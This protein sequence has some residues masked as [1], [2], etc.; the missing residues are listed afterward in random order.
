MKDWLTSKGIE[1]PDCTLK[2]E[3]LLLIVANCPTPKYAV[4]EMAKASGH[5]VTRLPPYHCEFNPIEVI[6]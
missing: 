1:F 5:E 2:R 3:L 6:I 4:D